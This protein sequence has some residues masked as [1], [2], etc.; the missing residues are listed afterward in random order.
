M[1]LKIEVNGRSTH[2]AVYISDNIRGFFL[3]EQ[4]QID[5]GILPPNYPH[6]GSF[7]PKTS[8][9]ATSSES[10]NANTAPCGCRQRTS[11]PPKPNALPFPASQGNR[12]ALQSWLLEYYGSSAF[13]TCEHQPLPK[14][15]GKPLQ[16]H[17]KPDAQPRAFHCPIPVPHHW[18]KQVKA[19]LDRDVR[20][21]I[22]EPVPP[23]TPTIWCS[24][25][26]VVAK[27]DGTPRR[28][29]DLQH[30]NEATFR[31]THHTPSPFNQASVVPP[32]TKKTV[33]DAWNGYHSLALSPTAR[34]ATTFITEW[35]RY[36]YLSSPQGFHAAG[37]GYTRAFDDRTVDCPMPRK[38]KCIDD[39]VLWDATIEDAFW[40]TVDYLTICSEGGITF[41][42]RKF[43]FAQDNVD[44]AGFNLTNTGIKPLQQMLDAIRNF[45]TPTDIT[46]ARSWFGLI[47]QVA[48]AFSMAK[49]ML[50]YRELLKPGTKWFWDETL[51]NLFKTSKEVIAG[52]VEK[53]VRSFETDRPTCLATDWSKHGVGFVLL[54]KFCNCSFDLAPNCCKEG[55][56]L[57]F[58]GSRFTTDAESRYAPI[59]GE[60]LAAVYALEKCRMFILGFP[61]LILAVD[62]KPLVKILADK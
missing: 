52:L 18:K 4:A 41:N 34:D 25:M 54:Q 29:V 35:G 45:P 40:H 47:N 58:A 10:S 15:S 57:V 32:H 42:P 48:Y 51:D 26:V 12:E 17:F 2:Q 13:N 23:G 5:L 21:G 60:A 9:S 24:K 20:L 37:D 28:T 3:S 50:P 33:L 61:N 53:G 62:L 6:P 16:I 19:D 22:I 38:A 30:L 43:Q 36:R 39:T 1:L 59:E 44:F 56:H 27:K 49:E 8:L 31:E 55:W 46:G 7:L 14:M 11:P